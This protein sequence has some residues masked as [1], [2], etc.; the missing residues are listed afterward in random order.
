MKIEAKFWLKFEQ[1]LLSDFRLKKPKDAPIY[2]DPWNTEPEAR[3]LKAD[4]SRLLG[5]IKIDSL[6]DLA[7]GCE[8]TRFPDIE[9]TKE[10][11]PRPKPVSSPGMK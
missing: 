4:D 6:G 9:V 10:V 1:G 11:L 2:I 7:Q 5:R 8:L 3:S